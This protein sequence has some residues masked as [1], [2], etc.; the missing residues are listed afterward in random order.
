MFNKSGTSS[1]PNCSASIKASEKSFTKELPKGVVFKIMYHIFGLYQSLLKLRL[2]LTGSCRL[3]L[4]PAFGLDNHGFFD[5][6][7][8]RDDEVQFLDINTRSHFK[9]P[10]EARWLCCRPSQNAHI[11]PCMLRFLVGLRSRSKHGISHL[12]HII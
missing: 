2:Q 5:P 6:V 7:Q 3:H 11:L 12:I 9:T 8:I 10:S 4:F 1:C